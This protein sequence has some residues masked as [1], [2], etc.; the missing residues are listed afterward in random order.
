MAMTASRTTIMPAS[1]VPLPHLQLH[2][3]LVML[4]IATSAAATTSK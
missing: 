1:F 3:V 2:A 4:A